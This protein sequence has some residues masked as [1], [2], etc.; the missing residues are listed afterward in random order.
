VN[1][2][3]HHGLHSLLQCIY[4]ISRAIGRGYLQPHL[5]IRCEKNES[6]MIGKVGILRGDHVISTLPLDGF[7]AVDDQQRC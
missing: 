7:W 4:F 6:V 2:L 5:G 1:T 3:T